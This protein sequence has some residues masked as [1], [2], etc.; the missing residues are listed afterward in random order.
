MSNPSKFGFLALLCA[1]VSFAVIGCGTDSGPPRAPVAG[2][3]TY[4]NFPLV[5]AMVTFIPES[6]GRSAS[7]LTDAQGKFVLGTFEITDGALIGPH[8]VAISARGP[9]RDLRPGEVGS[10]LPGEK[11][12]GDPVIPVKYFEPTQS[13]LTFE[14]KKG[15]NNAPEF[16][17]T[18]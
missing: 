17:L 2:K 10:G 6:G 7:G 18:E 1:L 5:G 11:M 8:K 9:D 14:V 3:V 13:G 4:R 15:A 16:N 12:P